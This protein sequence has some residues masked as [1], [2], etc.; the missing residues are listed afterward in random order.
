ME[1]QIYT[2]KTPTI[3]VHGGCDVVDAININLIRSIYKL[4]RFR[5]TTSLVSMYSKPGLLAEQVHDSLSKVEKHTYAQLVASDEILKYPILRFYKKNSKPTDIMV[6]GFLSELNLKIK[7]RSECFNISSNFMEFRKQQDPLHWLYKEYLMNDKYH[8]PFFDDRN[9]QETKDYMKDYAGELYKIFK[10]RLIIVDTH[11]AS[12]YYQSSSKVSPIPYTSNNF[13]FYRF[14]KFKDSPVD[15]EHVRKWINI[16]V[17]M[18]KH[19]YPVD[20]PV[21]SI[22]PRECFMDPNHRFGPALTHLH[23]TT[24]EKIGV[25]LFYEL[26][27]ITNK[28]L[29]SS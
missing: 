24:I 25:A 19:Y 14:S 16:V 23:P 17:K 11:L 4:H 20:V 10:D 2:E 6:I 27:K 3:F 22:D 8:S 13:P 18:F 7:F 21:V 15:V 28:N 5:E 1:Q 9:L 29:K 12:F 26:E